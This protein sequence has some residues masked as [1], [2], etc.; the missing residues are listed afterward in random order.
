MTLRHLK[1]LCFTCRWCAEKD[2]I[3]N[4]PTVRMKRR[5]PI[6]VRRV[7]TWVALA[8]KY[9][10]SSTYWYITTNQYILN[11]KCKTRGKMGGP[12]RLANVD[13]RVEEL[14]KSW[15]FLFPCIL[16]FAHKDNRKILL[17]RDPWIMHLLFT[18]SSFSFT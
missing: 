14:H 5:M 7:E 1:I 17:L 18:N 11:H 16:V 3:V 12:E 2:T 15:A 8:R 4:F 13:T 6:M 10:A 9:D